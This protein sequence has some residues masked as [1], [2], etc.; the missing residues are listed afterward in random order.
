M[1]V[2]NVEVPEAFE[3]LLTPARYKGAHGGRGSGKSHFFAEQLVV[4]SVAQR[5]RAACIREVQNSLKDSVHQLLRDKI[6]KL[7]VGHLFD[8]IAGEIRGPNDSLWVFRGMQDYNAET[9][10][11]LEDFDIAW[12]EEAQTLSQRSLTILR[13]TIRGE[14]SELWFS[15]NPR[16][17]TDPVDRA[18]RRNPPPNSTVIEVSWRDNPWFPKVL[19]EEMQHDR[20]TSPE[21]AAHVWD[22]DYATVFE[23]A[24]YGKLLADSRHKGRIGHVSHDPAVPVWTAWDLGIGD[25]TAIWFAQ[26][27]GTEIH[28][29]DFYENN[30][31]PLDHYVRLLNDKPYNYEQDILPHDAKA[32]ELGTGKTR[33]E[34]L[35][36]LGRDVKVLEAQ[37]VDDGINAVRMALPRCWFD[38][39]ACER[40]LDALKSYRAEFDEKHQTLKSRPVH[41]WASHAADAFRYLIEGIERVEE[42]PAHDRPAPVSHGWMS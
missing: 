11:S 32:R 21:M 6:K 13:P 39:T 24:Y 5:T 22:G 12:V 2:L 16:F 19:K 30:G 4:R 8:T 1:S 9:I 29:I 28:V 36:S 31:E 18:L 26:M 20:E 34:T 37:S 7:G 14:D 3:P 42:R 15:W 41:D 25:S 27:V 38:E 35:E 23:G 33:Q 17:K 40:G 10:K